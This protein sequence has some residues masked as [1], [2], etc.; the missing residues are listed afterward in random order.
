MAGILVVGILVLLVGFVFSAVLKQKNE[1][2]MVMGI[3]C[4]MV[5]IL[6]IILNLFGSLGWIPPASSF[7]PFFSFGQIPI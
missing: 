7:L 1:M 5:L 3:G 2:G 6:N 4:G